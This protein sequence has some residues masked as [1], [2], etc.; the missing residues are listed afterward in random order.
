MCLAVT[1]FILRK[2]NFDVWFIQTFLQK[3]Y[4]IRQEKQNALPTSDTID[5]RDRAA[6]RTRTARQSMRDEQRDRRS[7]RSSAR[8]DLGS[9]SLIWALSSLSLSLSFSGNDLK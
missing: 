1:K 9:L 2:I 7:R 8:R 4:Q 3:M 6:R 5:D